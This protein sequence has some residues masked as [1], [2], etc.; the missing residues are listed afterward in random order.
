MG[1][2]LPIPEPPPPPT[3]VDIAQQR[4]EMRIAHRFAGYTDAQSLSIRNAETKLNYE[5][6]MA[7]IAN[8]RMEVAHTLARSQPA[9]YLE[10][11]VDNAVARRRRVFNAVDRAFQSDFEEMDTQE[12]ERAERESQ[13]IADAML[14][15]P[16]P[17]SASRTT[18]QHSNT[19]RSY[20]PTQSP[21]STGLSGN[22]DTE[23]SIQE[24]VARLRDL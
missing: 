17:P 1:N 8:N 24:R 15:L 18:V 7:E 2:L 21:T 6:K 16:T 3:A 20:P 13:L 11:R 14:V 5:R 23:R 22:D 19:P 12:R 9:W 4:I 10:Q